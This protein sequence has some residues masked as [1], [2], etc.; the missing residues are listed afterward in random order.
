M[1]GTR[2]ISESILISSLFFSL[3]P[4]SLFSF[5]PFFSLFPFLSLLHLNFLP[6]FFSLSSLFFIPFSFIPLSLSSCQLGDFLDDLCVDTIGRCHRRLQQERKLHA[7]LLQGQKESEE[8]GP[9]EQRPE[10]FDGCPR[11]F[12]VDKY[13]ICP[14]FSFLSVL[15]ASFLTCWVRQHAEAPGSAHATCWHRHLLFQWQAAAGPDADRSQVR[16][17]ARP[18]A[19]MHER[20]RVIFP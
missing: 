5:R 6:L 11:L 1:S 14:P 3:F 19:C 16:A 13:A 7:V 15:L 4:S 8:E 9:L 17:Q 20:E 18:A 12:L 10:D 2:A